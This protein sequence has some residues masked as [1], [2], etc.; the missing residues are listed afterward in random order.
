MET[1]RPEMI[2]EHFT[3]LRPKIREFWPKL[4]EQDLQAINGDGE[5]LV[6]KVQ[7]N[8]KVTR[9]EIYSKLAPF[10]PVPVR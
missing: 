8:Y 7:E 4:T 6:T 3:T 2:R 1:F 10:L 9:D 5:L